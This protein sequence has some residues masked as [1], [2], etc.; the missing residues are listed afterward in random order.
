MT[1]LIFLLLSLLI[2]ALQNIMDKSGRGFF[3]PKNMFQ[4]YYII[5]LP[6]ILFLATNF[7]IPGFL[8]LSKKTPEEDILELS[9]LFIAGQVLFLLGYYLTRDFIP[10]N[11][12]LQY[13]NWNKN[14]T[15]KMC[16]F[17]FGLGYSAFIY[18]LEINGGYEN[19]V[20]GREA[21]RAGGMIGQG[22]LIFPS[23]TLLALTSVSYIVVNN[24]KFRKKIGF[25]RLIVLMGVTILPASQMG[26]RGL[27]LLPILQILFIYN[28]RVQV[29]N[30]KKIL[31]ILIGLILV[32][33]MY[34]IYRESYYLMNDGFSFYIIYDFIF[35]K[36]EF[37]FSILL[38]SKGADIVSI[39]TQEMHNIEDY[40]LFFPSLFEAITIPIPFSFWPSKPVPL[41][42][43]FSELFF[44]L[45]GGVSPTII[46]EAYWN[47]G[48]LGIISVLF[49]FGYVVRQF[50]NASIRYKNNN[51]VCL[52]LAGFFPSL[53]MMA[54]SIQGY[55]NGLVLIYIAATIMSIIFSCG[56]KESAIKILHG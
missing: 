1:S 17:F 32:F 15:N 49:I 9:I 10:H 3:N 30:F 41:S 55:L 6:S 56:R 37:F 23:T 7:D 8:N 51:S 44:G 53:I 35:E 29:V 27:M 39:V 40:K 20:A 24:E 33:T 54:E 48:F 19:F 22:W 26:F 14:W 12:S 42:I 21:W 38:R 52:L 5:Q 43:Q 4:L 13:S 28:L 31:P 45:T 2:L 16:L 11:I 18:L 50:V 36:P 47:G 46:G 34:G 25:L